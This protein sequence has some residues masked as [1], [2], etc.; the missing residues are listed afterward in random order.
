MANLKVIEHIPSGNSIY[1]QMHID[2]IRYNT[3]WFVCNLDKNI[4]QYPTWI[5]NNKDVKQKLTELGYSF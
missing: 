3:M 2:S 1:C 5:D 4:T